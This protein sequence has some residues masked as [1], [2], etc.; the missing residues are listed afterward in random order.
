MTDTD[1]LNRLAERVGIM[2]SYHDLSGTLHVAPV[3][4]KQALL[5]AM[6]LD[7]S[8]PATALRLLDEDD[9]RR[10]LPRSIVVEAQAESRIE[11]AR[12]EVKWRLAGD[13]RTE[14]PSLSGQSEDH[15]IALPPLPIGLHLLFA[16]DQPTLLVAAPPTA[17]DLRSV[18]LGPPR[19]GVTTALY[20]LTSDRNFGLGTYR[21]LATA[22]EAM[23][24]HGADFIGVNPVHALGAASGTISP[25]SPTHRGFLNTDHIATDSGWEAEAVAALRAGDKVDHVASRRILLD[26]LRAEYD[27]ITEGSEAH[28]SFLAFKRAAGGS[29]E[30]F[31]VFEALSLVHG[32]DWRRWPA[33]YGTPTGTLVR[34]F[35]AQNRREVDFHAYLQW[36]A[37]TQLGAAQTQ[38]RAA[39]MGLGLYVDLAIGVRADGAEIW[40]EPNAF[41]RGVSLGTPPD[42]FNS[43]GQVW[44]LAP[45]SPLGLSR[46]LYRPF[47]DT[48]R[49][50]FKHAGLARIDHVLG[51]MRCFWVPESGAYEGAPGGYVRYPWDVLLAITKVEAHHAGCVVIGEDLGVLPEGLRER[52]AEARLYGC[53]VVQFERDHEGRLRHPSEFRPATLASFGTH[54]TATLRGFWKGWEIDRQHA[55]GQMDDAARDR[56][57]EERGRD[58][59]RLQDLLHGGEAPEDLD[60]SGIAAFHAMLADAGSELIAVQLDDICARVEQPNFPGTVEEYPNWRLKAPISVDRLGELAV[61]DGLDAAVKQVRERRG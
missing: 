10:R 16:D 49:T 2:P 15:A 39:G 20:G 3:E 28:E 56:T 52:L 14:A 8:D 50:V 35:A 25:Y 59:Q 26:H 6:G 34:A 61:L 38:A 33:G 12:G 11:V 42:Q 46:D 22:A 54:D 21:D 40:A 27:A 30:D 19:W 31:A 29:L 48:V 58:R 24:G 23:A 4:T 53:A 41:A 13:P 45:M 9:A 57:K 32:A 51:F 18:G 44:G 60:E 37:D 43:Q 5:A 7:P 1:L 17:P 55:F 36:R 47:V